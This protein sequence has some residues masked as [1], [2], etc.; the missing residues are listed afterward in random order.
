MLFSSL[1]FIFGFLPLVLIC[2]F[3]VPKKFRNIILIIFSLIFYAWGEPIYIVLMIFSSLVDFVN[4]KMIEKYYDDKKKKKIFLIISIVINLS[5][6]GFFKYMPFLIDNLNSLF[7]LSITPLDLALPIGISFYTF[8]TMSYSLDVYMGHVKAE[9]N[10]WNFLA[11]V[12]M[13]PQLIA[14]PIVRYETIRDE[15]QERTVNFSKYSEGFARF[16]RGLY[17][18]VLI[19]NGMGLLFETIK[20]TSNISYVA[21]W[22]M[23]IAFAFQI[24]FDFSGYSDMAI[25]MGKML[26]FSFLEN[27][28]YPYIAKSITDFWRRWHIS[29]STFFRD[30]L[31]IPLGG[32]RCSKLLNIRNIFV[33]WLLTGIW[34]GAAWNF[35]FWG[36][37]YGVILILEK[38][39]F[40]KYIEKWPNFLKHTYALILILIG[41]LIFAFDDTKELYKYAANLLFLNKIPFINIETFYLLKNYGVLLLI[42]TVLSTPLVKNLSEKVFIHKNC[43]KLFKIVGVIVYIILFVITIAYLV[44]GAYNPFLYFRF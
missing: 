20:A 2:Y 32:N 13:F 44:D 35:M 18:K 6:L 9:K 31:Y 41:W 19:A 40:G 28:N 23:L 11:Y 37:Y 16:L 34:H 26:G 22:L 3:I 1:L 27:F 4:G 10:F 21:T 12:S 25:G 8:Q 14:G 24:Y 7:H 43:A 15:L 17:K 29:L 36:I 33:V 30:Y 39:V 38:F 5:L 42:A